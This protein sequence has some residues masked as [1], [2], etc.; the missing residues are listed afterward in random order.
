MES[1]RGTYAP[2]YQGCPYDKIDGVAVRRVPVTMTK[3]ISRIISRGITVA[4]ALVVSTGVVIGSASAQTANLNVNIDPVAIGTAIVGAVNANANREGCIDNVV[5]TVDFQ[6]H[7]KFNVLAVNS[8]QHPFLYSNSIVYYGS[9]VCGGTTYGI[10]AFREGEF[11]HE[12][13]GGWINW[14]M[15]GNFKRDGDG[16]KHVVFSAR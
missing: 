8:S 1:L 14:E 3:S 9:A 15:L 7:Q 10:W 2:K 12:G 5:Q 13:D 16:G 11:T 6:T 4:V